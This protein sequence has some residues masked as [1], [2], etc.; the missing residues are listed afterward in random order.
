MLASTVDSKS[1]LIELLGISANLTHLG[2]VSLQLAYKKYMAFLVACQTLSDMIKNWTW[3]IKRPTRTELIELFVSKSFFHSHYQRYFSKVADYPN[4]IAWL[5]EEPDSVD[6]DVWGVQ[7][8]NYSFTEL[9]VWLQN[10]GTL[11]LDEEDEEFEEYKVVKKGKGKVEKKKGKKKKE[12]G[13][14]HKES[15]KRAK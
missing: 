7:K 6:I 5:E 13:R 3:P 11:E 9:R 4:M 15:S 2:N 12:K 14:E 10:G 1:Q 8:D